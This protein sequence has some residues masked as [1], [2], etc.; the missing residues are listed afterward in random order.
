MSV[1]PRL[2]II[3]GTTA[4]GKSAF[5]YRHLAGL[6]LTIINADS[7]QIYQ[8]VRIASAA[9]QD[10]ELR[11]FPHALY[12]FLPVQ[13]AFS[14][15]AFARAA[16]EAI[17]KSIGEGRVPL[18]CGGTYFYLHALLYGLL[19]PLEIPDAI[20][21]RVEGLSA[22]AAYAELKQVDPA[23]AEANH[24]HNAVRVRRALMVC[25]SA[26]AP[27]STLTRQNGIA[28]DYEIRMLIFDG[29]RALLR[30]RSARRLEAMFAQGLAREVDTLMQRAADEGRLVTWKQV[31][32]FTGIGIREFFEAYERS[33]KFPMSLS[34]EEL[35]RVRQAIEVNT[36]GLIKRQQTWFRN[37]KVRPEHTKTVDPAYENER[38]AKFVGEFAGTPEP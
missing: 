4:A 33:G 14:A 2:I 25:L 34:G 15:G 10:D 7:R 18:L 8:G 1:L 32:A 6:P 35:A 13:E 5:I 24:P 21:S 27:M 19:P 30:E 20:R 12:N 16:R 38:I 11:V 29:D 9:P 36:G 26:G 23:A 17:A 37:V 3:T 22:E 31:P 28:A